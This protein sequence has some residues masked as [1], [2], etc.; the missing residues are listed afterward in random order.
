MTATITNIDQDGFVGAKTDEGQ[1]LGFFPRQI[2]AGIKVGDR[3]R[4]ELSYFSSGDSDGHIW[5][6]YPIPV[7][8]RVWPKTP[9]AVLADAVVQ[10]K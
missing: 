2:F 6:A 1:K 5:V 8:V 10:I 7:P 9:R 4:A 3:V